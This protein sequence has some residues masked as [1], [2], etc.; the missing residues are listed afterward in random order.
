MVVKCFYKLLQ[1]EDLTVIL[2]TPAEQC[3]EVDDRFGQESLLQQ[4][5]EGRVTTT[6]GEF[7]VIFVR[8]QWTVDIGWNLPSKCLVETVVLWRGR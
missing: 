2:R 8:D 4:I 6:L 1:R 3:N 7:L 5:L